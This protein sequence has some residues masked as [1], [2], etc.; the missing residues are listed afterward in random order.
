MCCDARYLV[1]NSEATQNFTV[2][3]GVHCRHPINWEQ[4]HHIRVGQRAQTDH[5]GNDV[6]LSEALLLCAKA[7]AQTRG[8]PKSE[9]WHSLPGTHTPYLFL[10]F[11]L[12]LFL[13]IILVSNTQ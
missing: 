2:A 10:P 13:L 1:V 9:E 3:C 5:P 12:L 4:D 8:V 7:V 6:L 11:L